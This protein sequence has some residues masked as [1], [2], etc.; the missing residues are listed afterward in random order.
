MRDLLK[1]VA[2]RM[3]G[4]QCL[5]L[6]LAALMRLASAEFPLPPDP[7]IEVVDI[8]EPG[9]ERFLRR[10]FYSREGPV[11]H[12][13][14]E[15]FRTRTFR[16]AQS[17][18]T[19]NLK[20][21]PEQ[22]NRV[23]LCWKAGNRKFR[24]RAGTFEE[25]VGGASDN[26]ANIE[27]TLPAKVVGNRSVLAVSFEA[28]NPHR[29]A[30]G[31]KDR[32]ELAAAVDWIRVEATEE[33]EIKQVDFG[34]PGD[35]DA[36]AEG[37]HQHEGPY[38]KSKL[39]IPRT[40]TFRWTRETFTM[41]LP[42]YPQRDNMI[43][44]RMKLPR[45]VFKAQIGEWD[46][47]LY[48][49]LGNAL[50]H[51]I[52]VPR[53]AIGDRKTVFLKVS[54]TGAWR[55]RASEKDKRTLISLVD[56]ARIRPARKEEMTMDEITFERTPDDVPVRDRMRGVEH[57]PVKDDI[58]SYLAPK[59]RSGVNVVTIGLANGHVK[60]NFPSKYA[61]AADQMDPA[62]APGII[63]AL[64]REGI[65][66]IT[67][68]PFNVQDLRRIED[69]EPAKKFPDWTMKFIEKPA[70]PKIGMC[71]IS[72]PYREHH[73]KFLAEAA[74][75]DIDAM[76]FDGFYLG[77]IPHPT[78]PGC[79]C[80]FCGEKFKKETG[81]DLPEKVDWTD[82]A[83]KRWV[84][85][86][87]EKLIETAIFFRDAVR[88]VKPGL[89]ITCNFNHWPFGNK[90]WDT[91]IPLWRVQEFGVSEHAYSGKR[92]LEWI[93]LGFK[94]RLSHDTNPEHADIWRMSRPAPETKT[95]EEYEHDMLTF[96]LG[97]LS[98]GVVPWHGNHILPIEAEARVHA[99]L[100]K[101]E[102]F[103][104]RR[105]VQHAAVWVSQNT[106]DFY[107]HLPGTPN[108]SDYRDAVIGNWLAL[109]GE[110]VPFQLVFDNMI[111][112]GELE[113]YEVLVVPSVAAMSEKAAANL[114]DWAE[115]GGRLLLMGEV[116]THDEWGNRLPKSRLS[117]LVGDLKREVRKS[118]GK[119]SVFYL[120]TDAGLQYARERKRSG[121]DGVLE[122][123]RSE[124]YPFDIEAPPFILANA[125]YGRDRQVWIHLLNVSDYMPFGDT[126]FRGLSL[127]P[128]FL[129]S[130]AGAEYAAE[131]PDRTHSKATSVR[132]KPH[133]WKVKSAKLGL[134]GQEL[135]VKEDGTIIVPEV[136]IHEV[137]VLER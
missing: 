112:P 39:F 44:L 119:G 33:L 66:V 63:E 135:S 8:G 81:L 40:S 134:S 32:R 130:P 46:Y 78:A 55:R 105:E 29:P 54:V 43:L 35:E 95:P 64:H 125:F 12:S 115:R 122:F 42:V 97:A 79:V 18:F 118:Y 25:I 51:S 91:A 114:S 3:P 96:M 13:K 103:F 68:M 70:R 69:Y 98:H 23:T 77:G 99:A 75:F 136:D 86:R 116:G 19:V 21:F 48:S 76:W 24:I 100:A 20:T 34:A 83:F 87:N 45:R 58:E 53:D 4:L 89:P 108:L 31:R 101:R 123:I 52:P 73:A 30:P 120:P 1:L 60:A 7:K 109:S 37:F 74:R 129:Q 6:A 50:D 47:Y 124:N 41:K 62:W 133:A 49:A 84:R 113:D 26:T 59:K 10:G 90:D 137:L 110:H 9:D 36:A 121:L 85:W 72:S 67:W 17:A 126:G 107:G 80:S 11:L 82:N 93:M 106:H 61:V 127:P 94:S 65:A 2:L 128:M 38:P 132:V 117:K 131:P 71:V 27:W 104:S 92:E 102:R 28:I 15:W 88:K 22:D 14:S 111:E 5:A 57:R 16:W 56:W